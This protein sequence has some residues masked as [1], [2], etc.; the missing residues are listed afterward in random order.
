MLNDRTSG[1]ANQRQ[2]IG[3]PDEIATNLGVEILDNVDRVVREAVREEIEQ[4]RR[5]LSPQSP[6]DT[7]QA[8]EALNCSVRKLDQLVAGGDLRPLRLGRKRLFP[9]QQ[10]EGLL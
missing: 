9:R 3:E 5:Q 8:C 10:I 7:K 6:L 4:F 1:H 2:S